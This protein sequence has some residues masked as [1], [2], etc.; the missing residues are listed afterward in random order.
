MTQSTRTVLIAFFLMCSGAC[1][2]IYRVAWLREL[3][4]VFGSTTASSAAVVAIFMGGLG[5]GN[6]VLGKKADSK[7]NP[8]WFYARLE[9]SISVIV[10][11]T[12]LLID[13]TRWAYINL[14]GQM[15]LGA[16]GATLIRLLFSALVILLPTILMGGT[17]PAAVVAATTPE[18][19]N[20]HTAGLLYGINTLGAVVGTL[21][22]TFLLLAWLGTRTTLWTA[23]VLNFAIAVLAGLLSRY[24]PLIADATSAD[25]YELEVKVELAKS[26][27][28][29]A[30]HPFSDHRYVYVSAAIVGF[31]FMLMELVWYRM[32]APILGG[33]TYT[34]GL[35]LAVALLGIGIGGA[36]YPI[37]FRRHFSPNLSAL[38]LTCGLEAVLIA[39]PFSL[40]D[41]LAYWAEILHLINTHG[42]FGEIFGWALIASVVVLPASIVSGVQ[43]P[44]LV[45]L[46]G[47]AKQDIG[48]QMGYTYVAN[49]LGC[50]LGSLAGGFGLLPLLTAPGAWRLVVAVLVALSVGLTLFLFR[51][52]NALRPQM[53]N[54]GIGLIALLLLSSTGPTAFWRHS[55]IGAGRITVPKL[56]TP[57]TIHDWENRERRTIIWQADGVESGVAIRASSGLAFIINGKSDG[58]AIGDAE[59]QIGL[60]ILPALL[61]PEPKSCLV[62]GLGTGE[63]TG[64]LA[65]VN[66]VKHV[67][68]VEIEPAITEMARRCASVN[69]DVLANPKV[70]LIYNDAR[71]VL[72]TTSSKYDII[73]SEPSNPYRA[74]IANL[75][76][77][78]FYLSLDARLNQGGLFVQWLQGYE[79]DETTVCTVIATL[80]SVFKYVELWQSE[81]TDMLL[82]CSQDPIVYDSMSLRER[83]RREPYRSALA[84]AWRTTQIEG[85]LARYVGGNALSGTLAAS[86]SNSLNTD[87]F[88]SIEY[89]F[90]RTLGHRTGFSVAHLREK[91][92]SISAHRPRIFDRKIDWEGVDDER[93]AISAVGE[94]SVPIPL[95]ASAD[96]VTRGHAMQRYLDKDYTD[97]VLK[98]ESQSRQA[99]GPTA[100]ALLALAYAELG[101]EKAAVLIERLR[102]F[103]Q[104]EAELLQ[105]ILLLR[106][107]HIREASEVLSQAFVMLRDNPWPLPDLIEHALKAAVEI[108]EQ[109]FAQAQKLVQ[110]LE[111]PFA[112]MSFEDSRKGAG[113]LVASHIDSKAMLPWIESYEPYVPWVEMFLQHRVQ[114][115]TAAG[116]PLTNRAKSDLEAFMEQEPRND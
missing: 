30:I 26:P 67:D 80:K 104:C 90:A 68:V 3:R 59:T 49:T 102:S 65:K 22:S 114:A 60:G 99:A 25:R 111:K 72:L 92:V 31:V 96:Q 101:N 83:I 93:M 113:Y 77:R 95:S 51:W 86:C 45:A 29:G 89:G 11:L 44:L 37:L 62:V 18:D 53:T 28:T 42:F 21:I 48:K 58:N 54:M 34:F 12:P 13:A 109:N 8:L 20:R 100:M 76:T 32:L 14:G 17:L 91:A 40:G 47:Q 33:T 9:F 110:A 94:Q 69:C 1:T 23:C 64:W 71:E 66:L 61:H 98:W 41:H 85:L 10:A 46:L 24:R 105:G 57:N 88:N 4:L 35:I 81:N 5:I 36:I 79:I 116:H 56:L 107:G 15:A 87:D 73:A 82:L 112:V 103:N 108:A 19:V 84:A 16:T 78:E 97:M 38:S 50:I 52:R 75:F 7:Q 115:Y 39:I 55:G 2:L 43:F 6:A 106:Q 63:T 74:G 70:R 27:E